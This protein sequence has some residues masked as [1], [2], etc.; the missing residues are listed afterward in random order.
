MPNI[1]SDIVDAYVFRRINA[2]VQFL[3]FLRR[4]DV[5]LGNTWQSIHD[6]IE[7]GETAMAA[8]E[9]ALKERTGLMPV[10]AYSADYINQFYDHESDTIILAPVFAFTVAPRARV[11]LG[12]EY[13]DS[14][15]CD[16]EE[17][18]ARL[19]WAGQRW[20]VRHIDDVIGMGSDDAEFYRVR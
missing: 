1:A 9:R 14:A 4:P 2:R 8:A 17:A 13:A 10:D 20:A 12:E 16:R 7:P 19:L 5:P 11:Q 15:W 3:L 18:T 6:K